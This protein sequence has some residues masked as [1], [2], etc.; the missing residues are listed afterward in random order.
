[1]VSSNATRI[2]LVIDEVVVIGGDPH[3]RHAIHDTLAA[4]LQEQLAAIDGDALRR[5]DLQVGSISTSFRRTDLQ[6]GSIAF[7]D[8]PDVWPGSTHAL[9]RAVAAS[10]VSAVRESSTPPADGA[11]VLPPSARGGER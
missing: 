10:I 3:D 5:T 1:M 8:A 4:H 11:S 6:V 9:A 7:T 2:E